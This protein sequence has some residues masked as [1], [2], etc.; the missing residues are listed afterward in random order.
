MHILNLLNATEL[1]TL[2]WSILYFVNF[3][4]INYLKK[5]TNG[6]ESICPTCSSQGHPSSAD[7]QLIP[8]HVSKPSQDQQNH[9][10]NLQTHELS[11]CLLFYATEFCGGLLCNITVAI[12]TK[13]SKLF[14]LLKCYHIIFIHC[15][16]S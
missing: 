3:T 5:K 14:V 8:R 4:S 13:Y 16:D 1:F 9:P 11:E 6:A 2:K 15:L 7:S 10:V 12:R